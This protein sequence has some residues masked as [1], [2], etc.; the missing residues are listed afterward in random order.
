[1]RD[2]HAAS[3]LSDDELEAI[4]DSVRALCQDFPGE[5]WR[6]LD[7]KRE[8]PTAF[9]TAMTEAGFMAALIPEEYG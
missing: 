8:Y 2:D 7:E 4:R 5:Y 9:V 3:D 1:M 6:E